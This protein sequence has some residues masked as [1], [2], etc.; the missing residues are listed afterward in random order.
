MC[1]SM[2]DIQSLTAEIR[3]GK[4]DRKKLQGK[5]VM[6]PLLHRVAIKMLELSSA[7]LPVPSLL[8]MLGL[9]KRNFKYL[10]I[11]TFIQLYISMVRSHLDYC[12]P[13][14]RGVLG[15]S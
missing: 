3:R 14:T 4:K 2:V 8:M 13:V 9:I 5:N 6:S 12:R 1:R 15:G 10:T 11:P 7:L